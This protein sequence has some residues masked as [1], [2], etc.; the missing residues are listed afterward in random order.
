MGGIQVYWIGDAIKVKEATFVRDV[1][2]AIT[3]V[4]VRLEREEMQRQFQRQLQLV[5]RR[6][7]IISSYDSVSANLQRELQAPMTLAEY[8]AFCANSHCARDDRRYDSG[9]PARISG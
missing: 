2:Q 1:N 4:V 3:Q 6:A 7:D 8:Q 5:N 9:I